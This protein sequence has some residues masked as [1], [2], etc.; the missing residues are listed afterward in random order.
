MR[1]PSRGWRGIAA[2]Q[3]YSPNGVLNWYTICRAGDELG[4]FGSL[5]L[6][7]YSNFE[8]KRMSR[9]PS[10]RYGAPSL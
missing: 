5:A 8:E 9:P 3:A 1:L 4:R 6:P 10:L 7:S 2:R